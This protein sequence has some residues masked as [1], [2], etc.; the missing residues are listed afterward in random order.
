MYKTN[1]KP[2]VTQ[3]PSR[4]LRQPLRRLFLARTALSIINMKRP[5][6]KNDSWY[7]WEDIV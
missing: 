2:I 1:K 3:L 5:V 6:F 7:S 4:P